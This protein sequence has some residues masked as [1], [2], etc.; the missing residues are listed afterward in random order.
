[1]LVGG[2]EIGGIESGTLDT[3]LIYTSDS[4]IAE[5]FTLGG[6][7]LDDVD[8][9]LGERIALKVCFVNEGIKV[10]IFVGIKTLTHKEVVA[11]SLNTVDVNVHLLV[12]VPYGRVLDGSV[13]GGAGLN[14]NVLACLCVESYL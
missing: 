10:V 3:E 2:S 13:L 1:V 12:R 14:K 4:V 8:V 6:H 9:F 7:I 11:V 5:I